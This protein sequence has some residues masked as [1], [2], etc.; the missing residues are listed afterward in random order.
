MPNSYEALPPNFSLGA[1]MLAGAFAGI[2]VRA[3]V[4]PATWTPLLTRCRNTRS[5]TQSTSSRYAAS[6]RDELEK[7]ATDALTVQKTRMQVVNPSPTAMY[8]GISNAMVTISRV[9]GF[10]TLWRGLSSVVMG[11]GQSRWLCCCRRVKLTEL[12][13]LRTLFIS[14]HTKRQST[15]S[16]ETKEAATSTTPWLQV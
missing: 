6:T 16:A 12:Q 4:E 8:S 3:T 7:S 1:N 9:E 5:C 11:A 15:P 14:P 2:A 13:D 10:R